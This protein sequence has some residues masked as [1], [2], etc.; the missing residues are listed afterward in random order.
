MNV[1]S[2]EPRIIKIINEP[3][4]KTKK[5]INENLKKSLKWIKYRHSAFTILSSFCLNIDRGK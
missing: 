4:W 3:I 2:V 5:K 1:Y